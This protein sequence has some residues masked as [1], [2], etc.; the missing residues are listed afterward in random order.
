MPLNHLVQVDMLH[1]GALE[2]LAGNA[3]SLHDELVFHTARALVV[4]TKDE[5]NRPYVVEK[6]GMG[7][8]VA[9]CQHQDLRIKKMGAKALG[10]LGVEVELAYEVDESGSDD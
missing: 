3:G 7:P 8:F 1:M 5:V 2:A 6:L 10:Q 9:L 4:L